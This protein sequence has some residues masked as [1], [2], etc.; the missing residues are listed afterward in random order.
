MI[1]LLQEGPEENQVCDSVVG[2]VFWEGGLPNLKFRSEH[3]ES[4][5]GH[6]SAKC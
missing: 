3:L 6:R 2:G 5:I 4:G 1:V